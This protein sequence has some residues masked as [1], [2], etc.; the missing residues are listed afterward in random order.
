MSRNPVLGNLVHLLGSD[1]EFNR[2]FRA[3]YSRMDGLVAI[4]LPVGNIVLKTSRH[5]FPK[6]M[7]I[8]QHGIDITWSIQDTANGNQVI[9]FIK[10]FL[11]ILHF[12]IDRIDM[13]WSTINFPM[14]MAF[15]SISLNLVDDFFH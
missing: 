9:D 1:L 8:T 11:F 15:T 13:L 4:G 12:A 14:Q 5:R 7:D 3:V 10:A 6:F 2:S